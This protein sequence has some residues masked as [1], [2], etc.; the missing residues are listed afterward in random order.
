M[1]V[2]TICETSL[3]EN[4]PPMSSD[5]NPCCMLCGVRPSGRLAEFRRRRS[6][7][8]S[9][10]AAWRALRSPGS[11]ADGE[12]SPSERSVLPLPMVLEEPHTSV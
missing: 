7:R 5:A 2:R 9:A 11:A 3:M 4:P 1:R 6:S 8:T 12:V 10:I